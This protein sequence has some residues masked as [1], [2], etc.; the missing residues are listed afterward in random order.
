MIRLEVFGPH[1]HLLATTCAACPHNAAGC[2]V[3]PPDHGWSDVGRVVIGGGRTFLLEQI[4]AKNLVPVSRGLAVRRVRGRNSNTA[5]RQKKC[6][7]HGAEGCTIASSRRPS[8]C[9][10]YLCEEAHRDAG[11]PD[12]GD[13]RRA[14]KALSEHYAT[15]NREL[16][17]LVLSIWPEGPPWDAAFLDWLGAETEARMRR[18]SNASL[19]EAH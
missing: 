9:N 5:P 19:G 17:E 18:A 7:Y 6:V 15:W 11:G 12:A 3:S 8:T 14:Q 4:A 2:C 16:G 13:A 1:T 10:Y